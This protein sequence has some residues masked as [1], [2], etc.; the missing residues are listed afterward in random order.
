[1]N[2]MKNLKISAVTIGIV[3]LLL[4]MH[5]YGMAEHLY[6]KLWYYDIFMHILGGVSIAV[7]IYCILTLLRIEIVKSNSLNIILLT[8]IAGFA[9]ELFEMYFDIAGAPLWTIPYYI[10]SSKDL[11]NDTIGAIFVSLILKNK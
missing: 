2:E 6:I 9:W 11:L 3:I 4:I 8:F 7:S 5:L 10:D 1:M